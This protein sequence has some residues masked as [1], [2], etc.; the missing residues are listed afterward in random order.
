MPS[1]ETSRKLYDN[2]DLMRAVEVFLD[3]IPAA[4]MEALR[5]GHAQIGVDANHK[6]GIMDELMPVAG[7]AR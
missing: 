4:S 2:L 1:P 5:R 6:L 7:F 3:G